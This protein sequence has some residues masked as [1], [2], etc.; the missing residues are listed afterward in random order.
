MV[1]KTQKCMISYLLIDVTI[2]ENLYNAH[3]P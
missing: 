1:A 3:Y 2:F